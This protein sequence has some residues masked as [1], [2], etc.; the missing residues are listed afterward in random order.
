MLE[1]DRRADGMPAIDARFAARRQLGNVTSISEETRNMWSFRWLEEFVQDVRFAVRGLV[2]AP[3][4]ALAAIVAL[5]V[6]TGSTSAVFSLLDGVVLR[7]LPYVQPDRL[8]SIWETNS[9][10]SLNHEQLSPVNFMD[11][12]DLSSVFADAA[13]WWRPQLALSD[14]SGLD[15]VRVDAVE[16][17]QN[18]FDVL[19]V[20]PAL[21]RG[22]SNAANLYG[23]PQEVIISA[24]LFAS[25]FG[26]NRDMIGRSVMLNGYSYQLV[27]VMPDGFSFPA[28]TDVWEGLAWDMH[29][30][31]RS[32][33]FM[34]SVA[35]LRPGVTPQQADAA[36]A[37]L[38]GRLGKQFASTNEGWS[39]HVV[40]LAVDVAGVFRPALFALFGAAGL[41]LLIACINV[42]NLL[43]ARAASREREVAVRAAL[44]ATR[45]RLV[46]FFLAESFVLAITGTALGFLFSIGAVR[47]LLSWTPIAIPRAGDVHV[48]LTV[49][50]FASVVA[51]V[52]ALAFGLVPA[53]VV[54]RGGLHDAIKDGARGSGARGRRGR[55]VLVTVEV[56]LA[57][58]LLAGAGLLIRSISHLVAVHTGV[59]PASVVTAD[60]QLPGKQYADWARVDQFYEA[61]LRGIRAR[62]DVAGAG[63]TTALPLSPGW[64]I[65]LLAADQPRP[66]PGDEPQVQ[67]I[68]VDGGYFQALRVPLLAG[69]TFDAADRADAPTHVIVNAELAHRFWPHESAIG[70][71]VLVFAN[72]IGPLGRRLT[73][74]SS[75]EVIGV[76]G[77]VKNT[78]LTQQAEP[79]VYFA[80]AQFPF[81]EM[82]VVVRAHT[83]AAGAASLIR[84][85]MHRLDASVPVPAVETMKQVLTASTD[86]PRFVMFLM[87]AF[88]TMALGLAA[89]G[90]YGILNYA[91]TQRRREFAIRLA[92]GATPSGVLARVLR[93]G[94]GFAIAGSLLGCVVAAV[95]G[96]FLSAF[97]YDVAPWDP[98]T[99]AGVVAMVTIVAVAA[100][101]AP[102]RRAA[103]ED[104]ALALRGE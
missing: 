35:R 10:K 70:K 36:L 73:K 7:P 61:L 67:H 80:L 46:R 84:S 25:R 89:V 69:R 101:L 28:G 24:R 39:A 43:L 62:P 17:S 40:P 11:Y 51:T 79:A 103:R 31:S 32:A 16:T 97:L 54:S 29:H 5:G 18:L 41:L 8:V 76:V 34:E 50:A 65:R 48:N 4:F 58:S 92:L 83:D 90:I 82:H 14:Q 3:V 13:A 42:A 19:G 66:R 68:T 30:H 20:K 98:I 37:A 78:S 87:A 56:T 71:R 102:G 74:D 44:G 9:G 100:C 57:V 99:L 104:P 21:G 47:G 12:H 59:N 95:A 55:G 88:A 96:R 26:G 85:E 23:G 91:V 15:P 81:L 33:H 27:G 64:R 53:L 1:R 60:I 86:P 63:A 6:G 2:R 77:N 22:F 49:L 45:A 52:T 93:E 72:V 75:A 38:T 94:L